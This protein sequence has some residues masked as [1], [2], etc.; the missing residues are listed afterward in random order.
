MAPVPIPPFSPD[1]RSAHR[2]HY[3]CSCCSI[4]SRALPIVVVVPNPHLT[5]H[6]TQQ[7]NYKANFHSHCIHVHLHSLHCPLVQEEQGA[8]TY[9]QGRKRRHRNC[10][11][12]VVANA[13]CSC[14]LV[15]LQE[16][17]AP[18]DVAAEVGRLLD[19]TN[20]RPNTHTHKQTQSQVEWPFSLSN[21]R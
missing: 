5:L 4:S 8:C 1:C 9:C 6:P 19:S 15:G 21:A 17:S 2:R 18:F 7:N 11:D 3:S 14:R 12:W 10:L 20:P 13:F 16:H